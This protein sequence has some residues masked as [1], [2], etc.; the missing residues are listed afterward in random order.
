MPH[1][2]T[3]SLAVNCIKMFVLSL[4]VVFS[5]QPSAA[6]Q[7][8]ATPR[9]AF[10]ET[11][12]HWPV[13]LKINGRVIINRNLADF[14]PVERLLKR[15]TQDDVFV[16][17][18]G[19]TPFASQLKSLC[20]EGNFK[21]PKCEI[22]QLRSALESGKTIYL[23][24]NSFPTED[25]IALQDQFKNF[26]EKGGNLTADS[27]IG[28]CF[29]AIQRN[30]AP[31]LNLVSDCYLDC[32]YG[33]DVADEQEIIKLVS[34]RKKL[35]KIGTRDSQMADLTQ[36]QRMAI[37][38]SL[39]PFPPQEPKTPFIENGSLYI[40]G[41]GGMP[42]GLMTKMIEEAGGIENAKCVY[43]PCSESDYV[44]ESHG[45]VNMWKRMGVK[46][47]SFMHTKDRNQA[48]SDAEFLEPLKDATLL[49]FGGGRQWNFA[50]SYYG[51][52]AHRLMKEV[53]HRGGVIGGSSA[54]ASIQGRFLA[55]AT[56]IGNSNILAPG[57]ER[58][59]LSIFLQ[60]PGSG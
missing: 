13:K 44:G 57:Y 26:L 54:G 32:S 19:K 22:A 15:I 25:L 20:K 11:F 7:S 49:W 40:V 45:M 9:P 6:Q 60:S 53:L 10:D 42:R 59:G 55:R 31:G 1:T 28:K 52:E 4:T 43:I 23:D 38:R 51:T 41:G 12:S 50:D 35:Q 17:S 5:P 46:H 21:E 56:P 30:G 2:K 18:K 16:F 36:W 24:L 34:T 39:P 29:G 27:S 8:E 37:D 48:N 47:A 33:G 3:D 58:G 14:K